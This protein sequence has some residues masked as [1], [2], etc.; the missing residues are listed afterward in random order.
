MQTLNN[1]LWV[2]TFLTKR[3]NI[4]TKKYPNKYSD[5]KFI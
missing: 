5:Y 2:K 1:T 4:F 3:K